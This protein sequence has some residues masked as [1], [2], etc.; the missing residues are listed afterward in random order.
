MIFLVWLLYFPL[1]YILQA[2]QVLPWWNVACQY[3]DLGV[4]WI[5]YYC[6]NLYPLLPQWLNWLTGVF[7]IILELLDTSVEL[8]LIGG[9][10]AIHAA[11]FTGVWY[12][13]KFVFRRWARTRR[14]LHRRLYRRIAVF[15]ALAL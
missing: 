15:V 3:L 11:V 9:A 13:L 7:D 4:E 10:I 1:L 8:V 5:A 6:H 2:L 12:L 14:V